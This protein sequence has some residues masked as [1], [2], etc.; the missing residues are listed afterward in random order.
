MNPLEVWTCDTCGD[1]IDSVAVGVVIWR[2]LDPFPKAGGF[3]IV[4]QD[5]CDPGNSGGYTLSSPL[6]DFLGHDGLA[7][8]LTFLS[9]GPLH[10]PSER[11]PQIVDFDEFVDFVRRVQTPWYEE[12]RACFDDWEVR[13]DYWDANEY[14]PYVSESL[15]RIAKRSMV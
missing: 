8:L 12:A 4:H 3:K 7:M 6:A 15:K 10:E 1:E 13:E 5:R 14:G 2:S 9:L 11:M